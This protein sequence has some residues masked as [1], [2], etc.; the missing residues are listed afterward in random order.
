MTPAARFR[1]ALRALRWSQASLAPLLGCHPR[2]V[3]GWASVGPP[4]PVLAWVEAMARA[5]EA[6][7]LPDVRIVAGRP[8][9]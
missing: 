4:E 9:R 3:Q 8:S 2:T 7:P 1:A 6:V 5:I